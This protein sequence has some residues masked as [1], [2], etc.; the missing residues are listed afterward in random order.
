MAV[1]F[2]AFT[3]NAT[4]DTGDYYVGVK[5]SNGTNM[6]VLHENMGVNSGGLQLK[7]GKVITGSRTNGQ[8]WYTAAYDTV[9]N[10]DVAME[11]FVAAASNPYCF[12]NVTNNFLLAGG[13]LAA[14]MGLLNTNLTSVGNITT[15]E[16]DL[17]SYTLAA[18]QLSAVTK[19]IYIPFSG[20]SANNANA[21]TVKPKLGGTTLAT[22]TLT[23][24]IVDQWGGWIYVFKTGSN[25][26]RV[27]G[28]YWHTLVT[29]VLEVKPIGLAM[30]LTDTS[31]IIAKRTGDATATNDIVEWVSQAIFM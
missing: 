6:A 10:V 30:A 18:N 28:Q 3:A 8:A 5:S 31:T 21:K 15:G 2:S 19:G 26:Q 4:P 16:D 25:T 9:G 1:K 14:F 12:K 24:S 11:T 7:S 23:P 20:Y 17:M 13:S 22:I 27:V 29:G